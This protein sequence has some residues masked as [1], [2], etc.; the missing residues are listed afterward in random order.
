[1]NPHVAMIAVLVRDYDEA[2]A[3]YRDAL[4]FVLLED[5]DHGGGKR[6]VRM[7]PAGNVHFSLLLARA[8]TPAQSAAIGNQ[9]GGRVGFFLH[10]D[11]FARDHARLAAAGAQF[12]ESP[13]FE[14]YGTVVVFRDLYGNRRDLIERH[15]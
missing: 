15:A 14:A 2:I 9:H 6:W 3:W 5:D 10:T 12:E 11:D 8:T 4:G 7:A 1:M 13:R